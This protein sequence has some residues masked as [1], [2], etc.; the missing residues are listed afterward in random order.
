MLIN[1]LSQSIIHIIGSGA[2]LL[3]M[4]LQGKCDM[5]VD[6]ENVSPINFL[7]LKSMPA[8]NFAKVGHSPQAFCLTLRT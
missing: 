5:E 4:G 2:L 8:N 7:C 3:T 6:I 1:D